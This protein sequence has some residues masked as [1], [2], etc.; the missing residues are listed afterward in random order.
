M[1]SNVEADV[2]DVYAPCNVDKE[3]AGI[4]YE[5]VCAEEPNGANVLNDDVC[6]CEEFN[7]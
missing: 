3:N 4:S 7:Y 6:V 5:P 1:T 2:A